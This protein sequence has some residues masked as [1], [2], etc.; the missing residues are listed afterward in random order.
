MNR[1]KRISLFIGILSLIITACGCQSTVISSSWRDDSFRKESIKK[2]F[3][4]CHLKSDLLRRKAEDIFAKQLYLQGIDSIQ[5]YRF[6][7]TET[8]TDKGELSR[9]IKREGISNVLIA[10]LL[11]EKTVRVDNSPVCLTPNEWNSRGWYPFYSEACSSPFMIDVDILKIETAI[12]EAETDK[13]LW[14]T[15]THTELTS[16][17]TEKDIKQWVNLVI[18]SMLAR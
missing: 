15:N 11:E 3:I 12:F 5:S 17:A 14:A 9:R 18:K 8:D 13:L 10:K 4:I 1:L 7:P 6:Y 16:D 2:V